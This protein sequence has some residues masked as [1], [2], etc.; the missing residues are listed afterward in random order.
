MF[1]FIGARLYGIR[2]LHGFKRTI[3][4]SDLV[5]FAM[6][7]KGKIRNDGN[8][9]SKE[10]F[11]KSGDKKGREL[12]YPKYGASIYDDIITTQFKKE[13]DRED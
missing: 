7:N 9:I 12:Y 1:R 6:E 13:N 2:R 11:E 4:P 8:K 3:V 5:I 10:E